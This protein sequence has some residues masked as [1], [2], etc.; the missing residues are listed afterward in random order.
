MTQE[1]R[2]LQVKTKGFLTAIL[3]DS[4]FTELNRL[5]KE[6]WEIMEVV[7]LSRAFGR[8]DH[9]SFVLKRESRNP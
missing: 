1:Y 3:P 7:R 6:G 9:V 2:Q 5:S 8:T 4:C